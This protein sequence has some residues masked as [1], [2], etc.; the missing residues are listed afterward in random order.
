MRALLLSTNHFLHCV[1]LW[2]NG[3][4]TLH[5]PLC[6]NGSGAQVNDQRFALSAQKVVQFFTA[7]LLYSLGYERKECHE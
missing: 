5:L 2:E 7:L 4:F 1:M 3:I 6:Q